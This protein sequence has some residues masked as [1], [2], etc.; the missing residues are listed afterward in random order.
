MCQLVGWSAAHSQPVV[1][2]ESG[3]TVRKGRCH[4]DAAL[5]ELLEDGFAKLSG[6][7]RLL[8]A[9]LKLELDQLAVRPKEVDAQIQRA[10]E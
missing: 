3:I 10:A 1:G 9:Q 8:L 7:V 6:T 4:L 5:P 2:I